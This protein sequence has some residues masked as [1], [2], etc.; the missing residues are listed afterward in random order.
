MKVV[1][2]LIC[3]GCALPA[4]AQQNSDVFVCAAR[5]W[6]LNRNGEWKLDLN[7]SAYAGYRVDS[8]VLV[9]GYLDYNDFSL[10]AQTYTVSWKK[11]SGLMGVKASLPI[12]DGRVAPYFM[13]ALGVSSV[14]ASSDTV[15]SFGSSEHTRSL[16]H[17]GSGNTVSFLGAV[18][19]DISIYRGVAL[20]LELRTT[21]GVNT[22][23]YDLLIQYR[24][25]LGVAL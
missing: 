10:N 21:F 25:G 19:T 2:F 12:P 7:A 13:G 16:Y 5:G 11:Y 14:T 1:L 18:G 24:A 17:V 15:Y 23:L 3:L 20:I 4:V 6:M 9:L 22:S 8:D